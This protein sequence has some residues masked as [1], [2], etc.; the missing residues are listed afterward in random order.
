MVLIGRSTG[1]SGREG[2]EVRGGGWGARGR[3]WERVGNS[4][5]VC[6]LQDE[7]MSFLKAM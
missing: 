7:G 6:S 3:T 2:G 1:G 4:I 5:E